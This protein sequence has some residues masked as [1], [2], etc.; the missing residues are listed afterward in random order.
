MQCRV[1]PVTGPSSKPD[2]PIG[3]L[4]LGVAV[5]DSKRS[6][7]AEYFIHTVQWIVKPSSSEHTGVSGCVLRDG[8][9]FTPYGSRLLADSACALVRL[10]E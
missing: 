6:G 5:Y 2:R 7:T 1:A 8:G 9:F 4:H 3:L 10:R